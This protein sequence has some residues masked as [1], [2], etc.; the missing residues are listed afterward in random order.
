MFPRF[1]SARS[2]SAQLLT[3]YLGLCL[4]WTLDLI[5][6][7]WLINCICRELLCQSRLWSGYLC[8]HAA[9]AV[10][11]PNDFGDIHGVRE[12]KAMSIGAIEG[13]LT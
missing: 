12:F 2:Y 1:T 6:R 10:S 11:C 9:K 4:G 5:E 7:L 8:T 3:R 13:Q